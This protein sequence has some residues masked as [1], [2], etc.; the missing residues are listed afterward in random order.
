MRGSLILSFVLLPSSNAVGAVEPRPSCNPEPQETTILFGTMVA[1]SIG[2]IADIDIFRF[3][4][5]INEVV[6]IH[7]IDL[8]GPG[9]SFFE[10]WDPDGALLDTSAFTISHPWGRVDA[11][12][13]KT[14]TYTV[15]I[16]DYG[17]DQTV[18]YRLGIQCL[19]GPC[20]AQS[21]P[22]MTVTLTGCTSCSIGQTFSAQL[23]L[24]S[25]PISAELKIGFYQPNGSGLSLG[26]PHI[27]LPPGF[28]FNGE[29]VRGSITSSHAAGAW[30]FCARL[31]ELE[32]GQ[33]IAQSCKSFTVVP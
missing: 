11:A 23:S 29:V 28:T 5:T 10:L 7:T 13:V 19:A 26:D 9:A 4:G 32:L 2:A 20:P 16:S 3:Q 33:L 12:L 24:T 8:V 6:V 27:A 14:G 25:A 30:E 22:T 1:C 21:P 18:T 17:N 15:F 31:L